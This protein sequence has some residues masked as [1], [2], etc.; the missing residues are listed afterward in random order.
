MTSAARLVGSSASGSGPD[1]TEPL[2]DLGIAQAV[3]RDPEALGVRELAVA[4]P[5]PAEVGIELEAVADVDD[6]QERRPAVVDRERLG[7]ALGLTPSALHGDAPGPG[8][9][10][11]GAFSRLRLYASEERQLFFELLVRTLFCLHDE[12]VA[13]VEV[14][15]SGAGRVVRVGEPDRVLKP[16]AIA[17]GIARCRARPIDVQHV[18]QLDGERLEVGAF[19][20]A[21]LRPPRDEGL[22]RVLALRLNLR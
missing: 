18:A 13:P 4:L 9:S 16:V 5:G 10:D 22:D 19:G 2:T 7:V 6:D 11:G 3:E 21:G 14:N 12:G 8:A 15:A 17:R 1:Q 20:G